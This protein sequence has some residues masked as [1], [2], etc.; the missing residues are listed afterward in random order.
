M[1]PEGA[2]S[3][4]SPCALGK[5]TR[6]KTK[7]RVLTLA[8]VKARGLL[9]FPA[10]FLAIPFTGQSRLNPEFLTRLQVKGVS[11]DF[12]NDVF[13]QDFPLEAAKRVL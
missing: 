2:G 7:S 5:Q 6:L 3:C 8:A 13:L 1:V 12:A 10:S 11:L 9:G 4:G